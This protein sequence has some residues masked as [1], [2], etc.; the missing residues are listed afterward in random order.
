LADPRSLH[1]AVTNLLTNALKF[2]EPGGTVRID[3]GVSAS[4]AILHVSDT[5]VGIPPEELPH[6]FDRFW[7]GQQATQT[8]GSGIG[9]AIASELVSAHGG[10]L[11]ADSELAAGT[12]MTMCLP[13]AAEQTARRGQR[14]RSSE[15]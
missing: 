11:T 2:S 12:V 9:L 10:T 1:H 5:G 13:R 15:K 7:R 14:K 6:I 4:D 3:T 8:S